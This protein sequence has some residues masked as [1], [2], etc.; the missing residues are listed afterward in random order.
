MR[1]GELRHK[2]F[3]QKPATSAN[4]YGEEVV[5]WTTDFNAMGAIYR[6]RGKEYFANQQVQS[7][8]I[9]RV[10]IRYRKSSTGEEIGP[11]WRIRFGTR[12]MNIKDSIN[13]E[14]RNKMLDIYVVE[15]T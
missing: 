11:K 4:T 7:V 8:T 3:F 12:Y 10:Q 13:V 6:T 9:D 1:A 14:E 15:N 2:L 5:T